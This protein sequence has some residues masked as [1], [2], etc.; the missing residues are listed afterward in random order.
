MFKTSCEW[1]DMS[2][3]ITA[4]A[5]NNLLRKC[6]LT[7]KTSRNA[8]NIWECRIGWPEKYVENIRAEVWLQFE[9]VTHCHLTNFCLKFFFCQTATFSF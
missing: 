2:R 3:N 6:D 4:P 5:E 7:Y 9:L 8:Q 1:N